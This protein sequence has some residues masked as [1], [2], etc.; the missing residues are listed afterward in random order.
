MNKPIDHYGY[1]NK[2]RTDNDD[3]VYREK[4]AISMINRTAIKGACI[5]DVGCGYGRFMKSLISS[6]EDL[7]V[8][9]LDYSRAEVAQAKKS[10]LDVKYSD[11]SKGIKA[12]NKS[13]DVVYAGEIIEHLF[14]PDFLLSE[15]NRI[16]KPHGKLILTTPNLCAWFNRILMP[17]GIQPLFLEPSTKSKLVGA[18]ILKRFKKESHPVGHVRIFNFAAIKDLLE[19]NGFS[20][21]E[22]KGSINDEG[23]PRLLQQLDKIISYYPKLSTSFVIL[24]EKRGK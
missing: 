3:L 7:N 13:L 15:I 16:L 17:L 21:L 6:R 11:L 10:G 24:S 14:D 20:I 18:G 12:E 22:T 9:G 2:K 5:L 23:F 8:V 4:I 19:M 1:W